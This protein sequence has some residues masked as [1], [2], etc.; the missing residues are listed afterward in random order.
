MVTTTNNS[1]WIG[2]S[3]LL[4]F[5]LQYANKTVMATMDIWGNA[6][7]SYQPGLGFSSAKDEAQ[8]QNQKWINVDQAKLVGEEWNEIA[9]PLE[10]NDKG[11]IYLAASRTSNNGTSGVFTVKIRNAKVVEEIENYYTYDAHAAGGSWWG[12]QKAMQFGSEYANKEVYVTLTVCGNADSTKTANA[13]LWGYKTAST[14]GSLNAIPRAQIS[15]IQEWS[16]VTFKCNL[17]ENGQWLVSPGINAS[18]YENFTIFVKDVEMYEYCSK[19]TGWQS[20][21]QFFTL[22]FSADETVSAYE[23]IELQL[24]L[25][26]VISTEGTAPLGFY[27]DK[28]TSGTDATYGNAAVYNNA[29]LN[30]AIRAGEWKT[31][32]IQVKL[33]ANK[34]V[35]LA[36]S[37][38]S[39]SGTASTFELLIRNIVRK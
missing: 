15:T 22:D 29:D 35:R 7:E 18:T 12:S 14:I 38:T 11:Q 6:S 34:K 13:G 20:S 28:T 21:D 19:S 31:V 33:D 2:N 5:G 37:R 10:L 16:K 23:T 9:V 32:T 17:D 25:C 1:G 36:A 26:G 30:A 4:D 24:E 39:N 8:S 27:Y 3:V